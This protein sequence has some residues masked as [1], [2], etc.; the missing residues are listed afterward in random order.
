VNLLV[1]IDTASLTVELFSAALFAIAYLHRTS[2][3]EH[4]IAA[5][6]G[7]SAAC[8]AAAALMGPQAS[9][10]WGA[11]AAGFFA[12][13]GLAVAVPA[14]AHFVIAYRGVERS[15]RSIGAMYSVAAAAAAW[16]VFEAGS[17]KG[18]VGRPWTALP[19][20]ELVSAGLA[21]DCVALVAAVATVVIA[22]HA[23]L[24]GRKEGLAVV[25]GA[26]AFLATSL[27][28]VAVQSHILS[29][30]LLVDPG[31]GAF[32][33]GIACAQ[34]ARFSGVTRELDRRTRELRSR[35]SELSRSYED[36]R[37]AQEELVKKEQL[38]VVGE[39]AAVIAHEVR[40]PL[41][42]IANAV[43]GLRKQI[44][45]QD[46][47]TLLAIL[48]EE[49][50]RLNRLVT[51]LLRYARPV[52]VQRS[53]F[54]LA[55][56]LERALSL[57]AQDRG[58]I[59]TELRLEGHDGRVYGD[60]N[61]LRQVFDNLVVNAVQAMGAMGTVTVRVRAASEDGVEGAAIDIIDT[62]EG[63]DTQVRT[64]A[65][66]PF[67]TTRPSGTGLGLAIVD[68]IVDA[69]GGRLAIESRAGEGTTVTVFLP[70]G[71]ANEPV[72]RRSSVAGLGAATRAGPRA[73]LT[74]GMGAAVGGAIIGAAGL[75]GGG[76]AVAVGG[77]PG[78]GDL[79]AGGGG[80]SVGGGAGAGGTRGGVGS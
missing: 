22:A 26:T 65:R 76:G 1:A 11:A 21:S 35:T 69:H 23:Y 52:S 71:S 49:T 64:R 79:G 56:V 50:S 29:S 54:S 38:A 3:V 60:S 62:G 2:D 32:I 12:H 43:S 44:S 30:G 20:A 25:I 14:A 74:G 46:H 61:L 72:K 4:G 19:G 33:A 31:L 18:L 59:R 70:N 5:V 34:S 48:D 37:A 57:A 58:T 15:W 78:V 39:L 63:M 80:R 6:V 42:I 16:D 67:F 40:N 41:A 28:D 9:G 27:H 17:T 55:D 13:A 68:R 51:D 10:M 73:L 8:H 75:G 53:D 45:R 66:D 77:D 7:V 47:E 24:E 36:L